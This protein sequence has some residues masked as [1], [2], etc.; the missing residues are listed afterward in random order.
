MNNFFQTTKFQIPKN[1]I[2]QMDTQMGVPVEYMLLLF[3]IQY[4]KGKYVVG[5][6]GMQ[7]IIT[8]LDELDLTSARRETLMNA[9]I[10]LYGFEGLNERRM[11]NIFNDDLIERQE[12]SFFYCNDHGDVEIIREH[13][14]YGASKEFIEW[15]KWVLES[16]PEPIVFP[17]INL[18]KVD[19]AFFRWIQE[20]PQSIQLGVFALLDDLN[21]EWSEWFHSPLAQEEVELVID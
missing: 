10:A 14:M 16:M 15:V 3:F 9:I 2:F 6:N 8:V 18:F 7:G 5:M 19:N 13:L 4:T 21:V 1:H 20:T 12:N 11:L 17:N